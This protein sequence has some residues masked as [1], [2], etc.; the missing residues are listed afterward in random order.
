[1]L[2]A[3]LL[4][5]VQLPSLSKLIAQLYHDKDGEDAR[6]AR[7]TATAAGKAAGVATTAAAAAAWRGVSGA[8]SAVSVRVVRF[9]TFIVEHAARRAGRDASL[10]KMR[11]VGWLMCLSLDFGTHKC[12]PRDHAERTSFSGEPTNT[13]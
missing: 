3:L 1:M 5:V 7:A 9:D 8:P 11:E 2:C 6:I 10:G 13:N 12:C 4:A